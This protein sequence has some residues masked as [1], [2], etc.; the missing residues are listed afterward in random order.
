MTEDIVARM[1]RHAQL[2]LESK[3]DRKAL[4]HGAKLLAK[5]RR[6]DILTRLRA[7]LVVSGGVHDK[8]DHIAKAADEIERLRE[9]ISRLEEQR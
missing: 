5:D 3:I 6:A 7:I 9:T 4:F 1:R 8:T 2:P